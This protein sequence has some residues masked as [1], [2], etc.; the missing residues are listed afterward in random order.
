MQ[1]R[2]GVGMEGFSLVGQLLAI[3]GH[4]QKQFLPWFD[5][6]ADVTWNMQ[7]PQVALRL[8]PL[9][10]QEP[11]QRYEYVLEPYGTTNTFK[12]PPAVGPDSGFSF[13]TYGDMG[14]SEDWQAKSP[15]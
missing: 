6:P 4:V 13:V 15:G 5:G 8:P 9:V 2:L 11:G 12:A 3:R 14:E 1:T 7:M 10:L